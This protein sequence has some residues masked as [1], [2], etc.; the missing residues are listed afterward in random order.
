MMGMMIE[1]VLVAF[2]LGGVI[3]A[4]VAVHLKSST[5]SSKQW[6]DE[7]MPEDESLLYV[8][9]EKNRPRRR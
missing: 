1:A 5:D 4:A 9:E 2:T 3:G 7:V 6:S 8:K